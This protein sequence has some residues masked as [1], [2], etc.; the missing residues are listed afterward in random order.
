MDSG[1]QGHMGWL[2]RMIHTTI[3]N[4]THNYKLT[5]HATLHAGELAGPTAEEGRDRAPELV[6]GLLA[7]AQNIDTRRRWPAGG[8][9][10][11]QAA[12]PYY[13]SLSSMVLISY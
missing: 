7:G 13:G 8:E 1:R 10:E 4:Y 3:H 2:P 12:V 5:V 6:P 9:A 11:Q